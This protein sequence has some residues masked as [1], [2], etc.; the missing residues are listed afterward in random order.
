M[1]FFSEGERCTKILSECDIEEHM[2]I[3]KATKEFWFSLT[4]LISKSSSLLHLCYIILEK[5]KISSL[6]CTLT[7]DILLE[8]QSLHRFVYQ[9]SIVAWK[10][11]NFVWKA[12][13]K[14]KT[15]SNLQNKL[16]FVANTKTYVIFYEIN[17]NLAVR[18]YII[19]PQ[20][21]W[22]LPSVISKNVKCPKA[23]FT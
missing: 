10:F 3:P 4:C 19:I 11:T 6:S 9:D 16:H 20:I 23:Y 2:G 13:T 15:V 5:C 1:L 21:H 17:P 14:F 7:F 18:K 12:K 8:C 22:T